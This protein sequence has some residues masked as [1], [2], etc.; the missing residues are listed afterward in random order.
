MKRL[1][2]AFVLVFAPMALLTGCA[3]NGGAA[4]EYGGK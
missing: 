3:C 2:L 1:V 4:S